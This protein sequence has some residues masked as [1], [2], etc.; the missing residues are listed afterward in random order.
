[1]NTFADAMGV[2]WRPNLT[3]MALIKICRSG[4]VTLASLVDQKINVADLIEAVWFACEDEARA[5]GITREQFLGQR[6]GP[7]QI[8][9]AVKALWA[10]VQTAFPTVQDMSGLMGGKAEVQGPLEVAL[11][12]GVPGL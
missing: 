7:G 5:R 2:E 12:V 11:P 3:A 8:P 9:E 6:L 4:Q 10:T 1:M